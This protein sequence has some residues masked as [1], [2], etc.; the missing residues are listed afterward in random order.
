MRMNDNVTGDQLLNIAREAIRIEAAEVL[1]LSS[2]LGDDFINACEIFLSCH[3]RIVVTG[4][5]KSGHIASKI[6]ATLAS[7]GS[8][9]FF[10][11]P[12]EA[13]HGDIGV[14]TKR[15][16]VLALSFSGNTSE[17]LDLIPV[18]K[19]LGVPLISMTGNPESKLARAADVNLDASISREA[20]PLG[21]APTSSTT[22]ALVLGDAL[23]VALIKK[24]GFTEADFARSHPGGVLGKRLLLH[25]E[26][27]MRVG[28]ELPMVSPATTV[29]D[30]LFEMTQKGVGMTLIAD[31]E[32]HL[33]GI[34][35]DGDLRRV[36][37]RHLAINN[38]PIAEVM[39]TNC[40][41]ITPDRLAVDA[42]QLME[43]RKITALPVLND[44]AKICGVVHI[45][46]LLTAGLL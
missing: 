14:I 30:A 15:D 44:T 11:H 20:C 33:K 3:D 21:L 19:L 1:N 43:V 28:D 26:Q 42:L 29:A 46:D 34:F 23:A 6:A 9:A 35:T 45:H 40:Q 27:I 12:S 7:T 39:T 22:V 25:V 13:I 5:G 17:V 32:L 10:M 8:P 37:D 2:R 18:I 41:T 24:R 38:L 16:V 36:L 31:N 4:V